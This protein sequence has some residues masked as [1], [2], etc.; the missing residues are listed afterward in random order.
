M[1]TKSNPSL[2]GV[3][4]AEAI[5]KSK[6]DCHDFANAKSRNDEVKSDESHYKS[7]NDKNYRRFAIFFVGSFV[8]PALLVGAFV[9]LLWLYDPL[10]LFHKPYFREQT[11]VYEKNLPI[12]KAIDFLDFDSILLGSSMFQNTI[13]KEADKKIG[14]KWFNFAI[15]SSRIDEREALLQYILK[16]KQIK[17]IAYSLDNYILVNGEFT[18]VQITSLQNINNTFWENLK[19]YF[20]KHFIKCAVKWSKKFECVG[21]TFKEYGPWYNKN[22]YGFKNW[23][24]DEKQRFLQELEIYQNNSYKTKNIDMAERANIHK[25]IRERIFVYVEQN[26]QINFHFVLPTQSRFFWNIP[27][28]W[29]DGERFGTDKYRSPKRY[30]DDWKHTIKWFIQESEKYNNVKIY[31]LDTLD[32]ADNLDNYSDARHYRGDMNSMQ[33]DAIANGTHILTPQ[34]I[35]SYLATMESKIKSYDISPLIEQ[36]QEWEARQN[37][38]LPR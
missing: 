9:G 16:H 30:F 12:N 20:D 7:H 22:A 18:K 37:P 1:K 10:M 11:I 24:F 26:P 6:T 27:Y 21:R 29:N 31:G 8:P 35:D 25:Y 36:I 23:S 33:L 5:Q 15:G 13:A 4:N 14:G 28:Y 38:N 19:I 17:Q 3:A 32:Y 2:R 34:N